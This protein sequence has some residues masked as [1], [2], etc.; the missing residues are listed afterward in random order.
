MASPVRS[1]DLLRDYARTLVALEFSTPEALKEYLHDHPKADKSKHTVKKDEEGHHEEEPKKSWKERLKGLSEKAS[2]LVRNAPKAVKQFIEDDSF[3]RKTL[4]EAHKALTEAP[5]KIA[6]NALNTVK[7]EVKEFK[8]A[9]QGIAAVMR[10]QKMTPHQKKALKTVA[11][12]M[13]ISV[14]AAA[15]TASGPL[16]AAGMVGKGLVKHTAMK[17][18]SNLLGHTHILEELGH[19]GHGVKHLMEKLAVE[20]KEADPEEVL[21][22]LVLAAVAKELKGLSDED[23]KK[24]LEGVEEK[25]MEEKSMEKS[26]EKKASPLQE[27]KDALIV[28]NVTARFMTRGM[29]HPSEEAKKKYLHEHPGADPKNHK[30]KK[31]PDSTASSGIGSESTKADS[32]S[33]DLT[34]NLDSM[35]AL[36]RKVDNAEPSAKKKFD[37]T[38][39]KLYEGGESSAKA[40]ERLVKKFE[41]DDRKDVQIAVELLSDSVRQW[42]RNKFDHHK[43]TAEFTHTHE[44]LRQAEQTFGYAM[45]VNDY[46]ELLNKTLQGDR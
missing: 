23:I 39:T 30:V 9:G 25:T 12:H 18:V 29:E 6:K 41:D 20:G 45:K 43:Q 28:R 21:G 17:A 34:K 16:A 11:T 35:K 14:T 15:L 46:I 42:E 36:K 26:M 5:E 22:N 19:I 31:N 2:S 10:G 13:A 38:Y 27:F 32:R 4:M 24:A 7:H 40:A 44:K 1:R 37:Q 8:E 33:K 3:R